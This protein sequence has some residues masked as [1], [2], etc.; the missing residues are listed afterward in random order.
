V[1]PLRLAVVGAGRLGTF[2]ARLA[3]DQ[4]NVELA[5]IVDPVASARD[6][7]AA[8]LGT[9]PAARIEDIVDQVDAVIVAAPTT[10]HHSIGKTLLERGIHLLMEKPITVKVDEADELVSLAETHGCVLQ[11]GH[12]ERFNP[13]LDAAL[14]YLSN[15]KFIQAR[16]LTGFTCRSTDVGVVLDLMIHDIDIVQ[17]LA[18]SEVVD[19]EALGVSMLSQH[20]DVAHTRLRFAN[21]CVAELTASR[22]SF[23]SQRSLQ[24]WTTK[25]FTE[26]DF[27]TNSAKVVAPS[28]QL[29]RGDFDVDALSADE[30]QH[31]TQHL[32]DEYLPAR[33][34]QREPI[35]AL[36]EEQR[37]FIDSIRTGRQ[38][39]VTGLHG[40]NA[41]A[42]AHQI[43]QAIAAHA[44]DGS[45]DGP[46]GAHGKTSEPIL[47][48]PHWHLKPAAKRAG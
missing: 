36:L 1:K 46:R 10:L 26:V 47:R 42:L 40:R 32:F 29:V 4:E 23:E 28:E 44:W 3:A 24:V 8:E 41:L 38:P 37:D 5:A 2:H 43:L 30:K 48:G 12:V 14:P 22:A 39:R 6:K 16:R 35:N 13:A 45:A 18:R 27:A 33:T 9:T 31:L 20:E 7:L 11:V 34:L 19:V 21:G 17:Q 25:G 15:P